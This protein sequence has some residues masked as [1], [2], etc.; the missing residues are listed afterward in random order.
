MK[1]DCRCNNNQRSTS[2]AP[3]KKGIHGNR[4]FILVN[5]T[6][7]ADTFNTATI[8]EQDRRHLRRE[9]EVSARFEVDGGEEKRKSDKRRVLPKQP[10]RR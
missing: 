3:R 1:K 8:S 5:T 7:E 2:S 9:V 10:L 6:W 4:L